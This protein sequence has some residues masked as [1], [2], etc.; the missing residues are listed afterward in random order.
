MY[1]CVLTVQ[2]HFLLAVNEQ[3]H[4][5]YTENDYIQGYPQRISLN[6][7]MKLFR[8]ND[9]KVWLYKGFCPKYRLT[10]QNGIIPSQ[11]VKDY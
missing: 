11:I 3:L 9:L 10:V 5:T 7:D 2:L 6:D 8:F 4:D 1:K